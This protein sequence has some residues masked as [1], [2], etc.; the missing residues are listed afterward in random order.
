MTDYRRATKERFTTA[1]FKQDE[2]LQDKVADWDFSDISFQIDRL[3]EHAKEYDRDG[4]KAVAHL[5]GIWLDEKL[6]AK[7]GRA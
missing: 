3:G 6:C 5:G 1:Q 7:P 2:A 4:L